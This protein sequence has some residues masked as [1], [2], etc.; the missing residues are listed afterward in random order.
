MAE[1]RVR[2]R[3]G[4]EYTAKLMGDPLTHKPGIIKRNLPY[5]KAVLR[6]ISRTREAWIEVRAN[7]E[8]EWKRY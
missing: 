3:A 6:N 2:F 1:Y 8:D 5:A 4:S 7:E